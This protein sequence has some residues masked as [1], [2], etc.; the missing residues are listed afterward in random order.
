[1]NQKNVPGLTP[2]TVVTGLRQYDVVML[3]SRC[4]G[5]RGTGDGEK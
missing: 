4:T 5:I 3:H 2:G 1:M